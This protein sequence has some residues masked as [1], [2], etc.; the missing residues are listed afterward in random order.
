MNESFDAITLDRMLPG[1]DGLMIAKSLR[2][3]GAM[4]RS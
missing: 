3:A 1:C 4:C 2:D